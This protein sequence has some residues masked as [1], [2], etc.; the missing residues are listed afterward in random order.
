MAK[1]LAVFLFLS[2]FAVHRISGQYPGVPVMPSAPKPATFPQY[3]TFPAPASPRPNV[4]QPSY[5]YGA[6]IQEQNARQMQEM[7]EHQRQQ[8]MQN[9]R[10][11]QEAVRELESKGL[12]VVAC[13]TF[14]RL[15]DYSSSPGTEYFRNALTEIGK[16]LTG[17]SP[18]SLKDAVFLVE[19][20][21]LG[22]ALSYSDYTNYI[23]EAASLCQA[24]IKQL[25]LDPEDPL[26]QSMVL[27]H[28]MT[29][30]FTLKLV[31]REKTLVHLPMQYDIEGPGGEEDYSKLLVT[32]LMATNSGQCAT[33]PRLFLI[34]A[35]A[36]GAEGFLCHAPLHSFIKVRDKEGYWYNLELTSGGIYQDQQ[37]MLHSFTKAEALRNKLYLEPMTLKQTVADMLVELA[38]AY[39]NR[40][41][42]DGFM[43]ECYNTVL[44]H[45]PNNIRAYILR[46]NYYTASAIYVAQR[47]GVTSREQIA[48]CPS[49]NRM[50][51]LAM[52]YKEEL[53]AMGFE[54]MPR[55]LY[56]DWLK[57]LIEKKDKP[58]NQRLK[59]QYIIK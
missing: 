25:G 6:S 54:P 8:Q 24:K 18:L 30:T 9:Q 26:A 46:N 29:D 49:A 7:Q 39:I 19:N 2:G 35:E 45:D 1:Y 10:L 51:Q 13:M 42:V 28:F 47:T 36:T 21:Y 22:N 41:G 37:Y 5:G 55:E 44:Q 23:R 15:P 14:V 32:K 48:D 53:F 11:M 34:L 20:A 59:L 58:E 12:D 31:G 52:K 43:A 57:D 17:E 50:Y 56:Q 16:M 27:F 38:G 3:G 40:Y 33:L 4:P